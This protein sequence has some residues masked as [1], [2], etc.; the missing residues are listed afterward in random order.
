M[1]P[2]TRVK[3]IKGK[4]Y[5]YEI[6]PF[7][8]PVTGK[9]RQKTRYLGKNIDGAPVRKERQ[10]IKGQVYDLGEFIPVHWVI[11]E[12]KVIEVLL[13]CISLEE[14]ALLIIVAIN[15]LILPCSPR[16]LRSWVEGTY[17]PQLIPGAS[18][19][20][21]T[22]I[23]LLQTLS[24]R[25]II[26]LFSRMFSNI[27]EVSDRRILM[28]GR[29]TDYSV[30][31]GGRDS[32]YL[33]KDLL[34]GDM[35]IRFFFDPDN[36]ILTGCEITGIKQ[37]FLEESLQIITSGRSFG[38]TLLPNWDYYSP[39]LI[40]NLVATGF[41]FIIK[42]EYSYKPVADEI[43]G[44]NEKEHSEA[45]RSYRWEGNYIQEI[46]IKV[47]D[48]PVHGY[49][50]HNPKKEQ[51][52]KYSF[53]KN[54]QNIREII[55]QGEDDPDMA[56]DLIR[57]I[58]GFES[59]FFVYNKNKHTIERNQDVVTREIRR[60]SRS[61]VL[62]QGEFTFEECFSLADKRLNIEKEIFHFYREF[63]RD[64]SG[65][66]TEQIKTGILFVCFFSV[67]IKTLITNRLEQAIFENI[68]SFDQ[69]MAELIPIHVIKSYQPVV[70]PLKLSRR[71]KTILSYFGGI[72][73]I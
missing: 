27:N 26:S 30:F 14:A 63:I 10:I 51:K 6:T 49:I 40:Q 8:D 18:N 57:E 34:E 71:Q 20:K 46:T 56:E 72:P 68:P 11:H 36:K 3:K 39:V 32:G 35:G 22:L 41:P 50:I 31:T 38:S 48:T 13:S 37:N 55:L 66:Q 61:C 52:I 16:H 47:G 15:R 64:L 4:E 21:E 54:L 29:I 45:S 23:N 9:W 12:Y 28:S 25:S 1:K 59:E 17:L 2:F 7:Q 65:Y 62:Y 67:F 53:D 42:P 70:V 44:W 58:T 73:H 60:L 5:L 69:L 19:I 43:L 33:F 24:N